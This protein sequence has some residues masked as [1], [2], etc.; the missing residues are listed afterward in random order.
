MLEHGKTTFYWREDIFVLKPSGAY[1]TEGQVLANSEVKAAIVA[2]GLPN[3]RRLEILTQETM[4]TPDALLRVKELYHWCEENGC[5]ASA[6]V[7]ENSIQTHAIEHIFQAKT[8][9]VFAQQ[10]Q[11]MLWLEN[12]KSEYDKSH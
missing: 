12:K 1:N 8:V 7:I 11:A 4:A 3:W 10:A 2:Q 5:Y 6:V 9:K